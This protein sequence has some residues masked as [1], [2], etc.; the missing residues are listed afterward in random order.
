M[1]INQIAILIA[2]LS[3]S[4]F[5]FAA[6]VTPQ[7]IDQART[8]GTLQQAWITGASA[9]TQTVYEGWVRGC[10]VG[11]NSIFSTTNSGSALRPGTLGNFSAYACLRSGTVSVLYHTLDGGSLNAYTPHTIGSV[12]GRV[13]YPGEGSGCNASPVV[14]EDEINPNN[15]ANV[16]KGCDQIGRGLTSTGATSADNEFNAAALL[17]DP[18]GP[19]FPVG[20]YS[21]VEAA[22][23]SPSIGGGNVSSK[24]T[25]TDVGVGQVFG[26][27]VSI[28]LYRALQTQQGILTQ[29]DDPANAPNI[30]SSQY[31]SLISPAGDAAFSGWNII[32]PGNQK[33]VKLERRVDTSGTQS[34]SNAFFLRNPCAIGV[35]QTLPLSYAVD[36]V[37]DLYQVVLHSGSGDVQTALTSASNSL[38]EAD[39][40]AIGVLSLENNWRTAGSRGG[41]RYLKIDGVHPEL[42]DTDRARK[43]AANGDY[44]FHMEMKQFVRNGPKTPFE[45]AVLDEITAQ[46]RNPPANTCLTFPRGLT[47]NPSNGSS[48]TVGVQ[49]AKATNYGS[50]CAAPMQFL[51]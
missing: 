10:D 35:N 17:T 42:D 8:G 25:E 3:A 39:Q 48:C 31:A 5:T 15:N 34:S 2:S 30:T 9:P 14:Y 38:N 46:L 27:A 29:D 4:A 12:L 36:S 26:V 1:K 7:D 37:D 19:S 41:Y 50:N 11:T 45:A 16:Y 28:P 33:K 13:K 24:G 44:K 47:L 23:F 6:A 22:L 21:D 20:G 32:L 40:F 43:T 49:I 51:D 18:N